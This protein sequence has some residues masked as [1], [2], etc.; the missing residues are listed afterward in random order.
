MHG[1]KLYQL[2]LTLV[3]GLGDILVKTLISYIGSARVVFETPVSKLNKVPG[4]GPNISKA[5]KEFNL[6][7]AEEQLKKLESKSVNLH[8]YTDKEYPNRL[9]QIYDAP[10]LIYFKGN[11]D[12]NHN[13]MLAIVGTRNAT[14]HGK[15]FVKNFVKD[16]AGH[17]LIII[18]G[19]AYGID[20][21]AHMAALKYNIPTIGVIASGLDVIYPSVHA[22]YAKKMIN[23][24]G[25]ITEYPLETKL[26]PAR[27]PARNR[28]IAGMADAT[29]VVEAAEKG[30]ALIT[31]DLAAGY[32]REVFAVP[33]RW[34]D[35]F[36]MGCNKIIKNNLAQSIT[37]AEDLEYY[38][39]WPAEEEQSEPKPVLSREE[40]DNTEWT[41][42]STI[43]KSGNEIHIDELSWKSQIQIG[44]LATIL[45]NLEFKGIVNSLPGKKYSLN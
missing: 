34:N 2:A 31:A 1:E 36:S 13:R 38:L 42:I 16:L 24:G 23:N 37:S 25:L 4:I 6:S 29:V 22:K 7:T 10:A 15:Q 19:L 27:F 45:L 18:S 9:K 17:N 5:I 39:Q 11:V 20:I 30:G 33:G 3:P 41:V 26:D 32:D 35:N 28:I 21:E 44:Q 43:E 12:L 40:F 14:D 8:F